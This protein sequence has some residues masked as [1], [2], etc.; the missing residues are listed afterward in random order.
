MRLIAVVALAFAS[1]AAPA[2]ADQGRVLLSTGFPPQTNP[3]AA[4]G[5]AAVALP[6]GGAVLF[7]SGSF[8]RGMAGV[9]MTPEGVRDPA[10][11]ARIADPD[12]LLVPTGALL[13]P[14]GRIVVTARRHEANVVASS[15]VIAA[16]F[17]PDG[18]L[19]P[20]FGGDGV[21]DLGLSSAGRRPALA[22]DGTLLL[23]GSGGGNWM[24]ASVAPSG[25]VARRVVPG[26]RPGDGGS[27][28]VAVAADGRVT[29]AGN[30]GRRSLVARLLPD[31]TAD[32][33]WNGGTPVDPGVH[34][35]D[36]ALGPD[37]AVTLLGDVGLARLRPDG[38]RD[39]AYGTL[40]LARRQLARLLAEPGGGVLVSR[41]PSPP[42]RPASQ[43]GLVVDRVSASGAVT[44]VTSR[45]RLGGGVGAINAARMVPLRQTGFAAGELLRRLDGS[46]L[47]AGGV[48]LVQYTGEGEGISSVRHAVV[49]LTPQLT[50][51]RSFGPAFP[52]PAV[53][54]RVLRLERSH[55]VAQLRLRASAPGLL[56][57]RVR[58]RRGRTLVRGL[59]PVHRAG[60]QV[61]RVRT[62]AAGQRI[63]RRRVSV[64]MTGRF[65]DLATREVALRA[66]RGRL[67]G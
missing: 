14:D 55:L 50:V 57:V 10:Y 6:D 9:R 51:D 44:T 19:D 7:A 16:Q 61:V 39:T 3:D 60:R 45:I 24:V 54:A 36:L 20:S 49:A 23:A 46:F 29:A 33:T 4:A 5:H 25:Q 34:V 1:L 37:G 59:V 12:A 38:T 48:N 21:V 30:R 42:P 2:A 11:S 15:T 66:T 43:P 8:E 28:G 18:G 40:R 27:A 17:M 32:P 65:R 22:P 52:R 31:G 67:G 47:V 62:T 63:L 53:A 41:S 64:R 56:A 26:S 13:R 58:D 35:R